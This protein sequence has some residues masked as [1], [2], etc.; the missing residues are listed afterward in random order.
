LATDLIAQA[1][2]SRLL[3]VEPYVIH[4]VAHRDGI[5]THRHPLNPKARCF[6][7]EGLRRLRIGVEAYKRNRG[8]ASATA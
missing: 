5:E 4:V 7:P 3:G 6:D 1:E 8:L 2:A